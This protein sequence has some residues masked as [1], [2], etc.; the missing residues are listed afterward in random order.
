MVLIIQY[1]QCLDQ[2]WLQFQVVLL[3]E[4]EKIVVIQRIVLP[5]V[6]V[7]LVV[8]F[9]RLVFRIIKNT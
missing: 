3:L 1:A 2:M 5:K 6:Q 9:I 4:R 7:D 8:I